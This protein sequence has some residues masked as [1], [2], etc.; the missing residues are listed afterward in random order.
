MQANAKCECDKVLIKKWQ[1]R[2]SCPAKTEESICDPETRQTFKVTTEY[3]LMNHEC[4]KSEKRAPLTVQCDWKVYKSI[5]I[6]NSTTGLRTIDTTY[7][8][9]GPDCKCQT[10]HNKTNTICAC[11]QPTTN[12]SSCLP[13]GLKK[14]V[15]T[16]YLLKE[17]TC[18]P[19]YSHST[20][21]VTCRPSTW[22]FLP[23]GET[24]GTN[25]TQYRMVKDP[26]CDCVRET[27]QINC[28]C[29][30]KR[31][32]ETVCSADGTSISFTRWTGTVSD[33]KCVYT[34]SGN[35]TKVPCPVTSVTR[36]YCNSRNC[37][38]TVTRIQSEVKDCKCNAVVNV[39]Q[40]NC[41]CPQPSEKVSCELGKYRKIEKKFYSIQNE[42]CYPRD[43]VVTELVTCPRLTDSDC[44]E[45]DGICTNGMKSLRCPV[46]EVKDC[47]CELSNVIK[48]VYCG[49]RSTT[50][51]LGN[52]D[53][54]TCKQTNSIISYDG[55]NCEEKT[56]SETIDCCCLKTGSEYQSSIGGNPCFSGGFKVESYLSHKFDEAAGVCIPVKTNEMTKTA[57]PDKIRV[58]SFDS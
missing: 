16:T 39:T 26:N 19:E 50:K 10:G 9:L 3:N 8:S 42:V 58:V 35:T 36:G 31:P 4:V 28:P 25:V 21:N 30:C 49:C 48:K 14:T 40:E 44:E 33:C 51:Q 2:C 29:S 56:K 47:K 53:K 23:K 34:S 41:C 24:C 22:T 46:H 55:P 6:C 54:T 7:S 11:T 12:S 37:T 27:Q 18:V 57:C 20:E 43:E 32:D 13:S 38:R 17:G 5:G 52:C 1:G 45:T 15:L